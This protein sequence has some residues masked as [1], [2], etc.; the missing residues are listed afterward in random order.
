MNV[1]GKRLYGTPGAESLQWELNSVWES[2][3]EP[4]LGYDDDPTEWEI[5]EWTVAPSRSHLP[6]AEWVIGY[7]SDYLADYSELTDGPFNIFY[8]MLKSPYSVEMVETW[9][10]WVAEN[11]PAGM[12][13][14]LQHT[15]KITLDAD[16]KPLVDG[17]PMYVGFGGVGLPDA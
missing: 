10:K 3:I 1:E 13:D 16:G 12:A 6:T 17:S 15:Y 9:L 8:E 4:L 5:E 11:V 14:E 2:E 7:V